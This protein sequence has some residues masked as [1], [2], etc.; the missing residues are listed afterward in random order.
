MLNGTDIVCSRTSEGQIGNLKAFSS[1]VLDG[2]FVEVIAFGGD[3]HLGLGFTT[4]APRKSHDAFAVGLMLE[5]NANARRL[6]G[7][8]ARGEGN[9]PTSS[10]LK[11]LDS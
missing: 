10:R 9:G 3:D 11:C 2:D 7:G 6:F 4:I 1:P 8:V 5:S